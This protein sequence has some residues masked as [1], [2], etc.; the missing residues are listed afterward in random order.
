[1]RS[2]HGERV[3]EGRA[4]LDPASL[5]RIRI[6]TRPGLRRVIKHA[7]IKARSAARARFEQDMRELADQT[8]I[9]AVDAQDI[10]VHHLSLAVR[11]KVLTECCR[12]VAVHI[13]F[14]VRNL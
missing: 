2:H 13:P 10:A 6:V 9:Q 1:M 7:R 5:I 11:R 4:V 12:H 8:L 3:N 14:Y